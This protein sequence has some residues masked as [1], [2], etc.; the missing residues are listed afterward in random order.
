[1]SALINTIIGPQG[2]E[3]VKDRIALILLTELTQQKA[4]QNFE[5]DIEVFNERITPMDSSEH[6]YFNILLDS[7]SYGNKNQTDQEGNTVYFIDIYTSGKAGEQVGTSDS[8]QRRDKF[9]GMCRYILSDTR[10]K[11]LGFDYGLIAGTQV[12]RFSTLDPSQKEDSSFTAFARLQF[13]VRI[14]ENQTL[15]DGVDILGNDTNVKLDLT[16]KGYKYIYEE[17]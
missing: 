10:Y 2:F 6:L 15:W 16:E 14:L 5:E 4:L 12:D 11:T 13:S 1:M 7:A 17:A 8:T 3:K 9:L